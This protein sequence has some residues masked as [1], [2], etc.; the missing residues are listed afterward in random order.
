MPRTADGAEFRLA[1]RTTVEAWV[2]DGTTVEDGAGEAGDTRSADAG[3][4]SMSRHRESDT[5]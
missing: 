4:E 5:V 1:R 2:E 3:P